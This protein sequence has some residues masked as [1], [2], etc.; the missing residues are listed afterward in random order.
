M[1]RLRQ[2]AYKLTDDARREFLTRHV[3]GRVALVRCALSRIDAYQIQ[4]YYDYTVAAVASRCLAQFLG[5][6]ITAGGRLAKEREYFPHENGMSYE[7]KISDVL[8]CDLLGPDD[9]T[10]KERKDL[11]IGFDTVN[12]EV[13]HL[14]YWETAPRH[15]AN[16][17]PDRNYY[18][19]LVRRLERFSRIVLREIVRKIP[20]CGTTASERP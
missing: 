1:P 2:R 11:E 10:E 15:H 14:T 16:D 12:R 7:V 6:R 20:A 4:T 19:Q 8:S 18:A 13:A 17:L 9:F 5:L 3:P